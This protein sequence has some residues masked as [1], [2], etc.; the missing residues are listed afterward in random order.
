[1]WL[2]MEGKIVLY[3][4]LIIAIVSIIFMVSQT[5]KLATTAQKNEFKCSCE[6]PEQG[7]VDLILRINTSDERTPEPLRETIFNVMI[8]NTSVPCR[9]RK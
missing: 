3:G 5:F 6:I 4:I 7:K 9:C 1:M 2:C 8:N